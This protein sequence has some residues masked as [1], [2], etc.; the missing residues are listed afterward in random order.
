M[1]RA[2]FDSLATDMYPARLLHAFGVNGK[3]S[4]SVGAIGE[5]QGNVVVV[6]HGP[7][8]CGF[9]YRFSAR[10]RHQPFYRLLTTDLGEEEIVFGGGEKLE[11]TLREAWSRYQPELIFVV[12]TPVS[13][14]LNE[15]ILETTARLR[16]EGI[17]VVGVQSELFSHRDKNY[18]KNRL[19][20]LSKQ[21]LT[22]DNHLEMELKGCGF[23]EALY[24]I[25]GQVME[26][27]T[28]IPYSVNIETVGWGS[29][30]RMVLREIGQTLEQAGAS[31]NTWIPSATVEQLKKAPAAQ[32][33]LV[34]RVRWARRMKELFGTDYLHMNDSGR[35]VGLDGISCFYRDVAEKLGL[36]EPMEQVICRETARVDEQTRQAKAFIRQHRGV[37]ILRGLQS[38]P[39]TLK[40]YAK[41]LGL[42]IDTVCVCQTERMKITAGMT[43]EIEA[44][45]MDRIR[46]A[47]D[48][49]SPGTQVLV[50]PEEEILRERLRQVDCIVGT[51]DITMEG[52][53][54][55]LIP[56]VDRLSGPSYD[57]YICMV[58]RF[59]ECLRTAMPR[60]ELVLS[61]MEFSTDDYPRYGNP[62]TSGARQMWERMWLDRRK[63]EQA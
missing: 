21:K 30:G 48:L 2:Y 22:G 39:F 34:K 28:V 8:G 53:G 15:S 36:R 32:L 59:S 44:N 47:I 7:L 52:L 25:V 51:E 24:A 63:G 20:E 33:N 27:Q 60:D 35:Y 13:D 9:H 55:P 46:Q 42:P 41:E 29:E 62:S 26:K 37:L 19:K 58:N 40:T 14:I 50:N 43:P 3:V 4:G 38:V 17:P 5:I 57:S 16:R 56:A 61:R 12:P 6:L 45:L 18:A 11:R 10:R 23:T 31:V 49:F 1:Y 54:A